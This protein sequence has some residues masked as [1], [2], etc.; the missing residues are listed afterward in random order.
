MRYRCI[1]QGCDKT[2]EEPEKSVHGNSH[3]LCAVHGRLAFEQLFRKLQIKE[4]NPDCYLR[5]FDDC[6]RHW[7]TFHPLCAVSEPGPE[8]IAELR[9]RLEVR[10]ISI[11]RQ[12]E[13]Q[14]DAPGD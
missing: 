7:C 12:V 4:G 6:P 2:W 8:E 1:W 11:K 14:D 13:K 3:G 10:R 5:S 9:V